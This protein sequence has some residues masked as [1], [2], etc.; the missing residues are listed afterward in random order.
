MYKWTHMYMSVDAK[1]CSQMYIS[2]CMN[3]KYFECCMKIKYFQISI[4]SKAAFLVVNLHI[5]T[6][7]FVFILHACRW[8][9]VLLGSLMFHVY[10]FVYLLNMYDCGVKISLNGLNK[11]TLI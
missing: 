8:I 7:I 10:L 6:Y 11:S 1:L 5:S 3:K 9:C 4:R 2:V